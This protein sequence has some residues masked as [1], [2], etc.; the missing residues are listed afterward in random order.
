MSKNG[1]K[2]RQEWLREEKEKLQESRRN[3][4][5]PEQLQNQRDPR[6][7]PVEGREGEIAREQ[8]KRTVARTVTKSKRSQTAPGWRKRRRNCKRA[9]ETNGG[10]NSCKI[11]EIPDGTRLREEKEKLQESRRNERWPEQLQNQR[12]RRRHPV[13]GKEGEI[14][15]EQKKRTVARTIAKSKRSQTAPGWGKRRRNCKRAEETNG[16]QNSCKIKEIADGTHFQRIIGKLFACYWRPKV[17]S[18][19]YRKVIKT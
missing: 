10:Q 3:E 14:A 17:T 13:E 15:R 18:Q 8:K 16:G 1:L 2:T 5:W 11:K 6:R 7:H 12:D 19:N 4:L 9:E